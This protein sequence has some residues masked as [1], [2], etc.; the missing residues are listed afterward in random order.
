MQALLRDLE[1]EVQVPS[2]SVRI[3]K[4]LFQEAALPESIESRL[5]SPPAGK[6]YHAASLVDFQ[7]GQHKLIVCSILTF[8][9]IV[10]THRS[11]G[12]IVS[13]VAKQKSAVR[14]CLQFLLTRL[15]QSTS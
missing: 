2:S 7:I 5:P 13:P 1:C 6:F 12:V 11:R 4:N 3:L 14:L 15:A 9:Y 8:P 10:L